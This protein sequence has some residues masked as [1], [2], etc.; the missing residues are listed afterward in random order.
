MGK[1]KVEYEEFDLLEDNLKDYKKKRPKPLLILLSIVSTL[2]SF[3]SLARIYPLYVEAIIPGVIVPGVYLNKGFGGLNIGV[4]PVGS[5][6]IDGIE[7][8][9]KELKEEHGMMYIFIVPMSKQEIDRQLKKMVNFLLYK[10]N[11][12]NINNLYGY[13]LELSDADNKE[14][15]MLMSLSIKAF[16]ESEINLNRE[17]VEYLQ[18]SITCYYDS[19]NIFEGCDF[20]DSRSEN[21]YLEQQDSPN[22]LRERY[23]DEVYLKRYVF[24]FGMYKEYV[25]SKGYNLE[26]HLPNPNVWKKS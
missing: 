18:E 14:Y 13:T 11:S 7:V 17:F 12:N 19:N 10:N 3:F 4:P 26:E 6:M 8:D 15:F 5:M 2:L 20:Y 23:S 21:D 1:R 22:N 16:K 9:L 25:E 24:M